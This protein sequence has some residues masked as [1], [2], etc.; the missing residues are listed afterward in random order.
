LRD[1]LWTSRDGSG[2]SKPN[3]A[4]VYHHTSDGG[5]DTSVTDHCFRDLG[6]DSLLS[7][8]GRARRT[9]L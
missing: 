9:L 6:N 5:D 1:L 3:G 7:A 8:V 4:K 2:S